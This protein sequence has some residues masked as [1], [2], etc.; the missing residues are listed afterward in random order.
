MRSKK[1]YLESR[2]PSDDSDQP[3]SLDVIDDGLQSKNYIQLMKPENCS[4]AEQSKHMRYLVKECLISFL[5][6]DRF[7]DEE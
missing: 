5:N 2:A 1:L 7:Q 4:C 6:T 3:E